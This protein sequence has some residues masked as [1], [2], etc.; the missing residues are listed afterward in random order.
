MLDTGL[1]VKECLTIEWPDVHPEP[2]GDATFG[3]LTVRS[4]S[5]KNSKPRNVPLCDR[6]LGVLGRR[7]NGQ[8]KS[9]HRNGHN[10]F[11][12]RFGKENKLRISNH[13]RVAKSADAKDLKS[14]ENLLRCPHRFPGSTLAMPTIAGDGHSA[15]RAFAVGAAILAPLRY[16]TVA[17]WMG[18]LGDFRFRHDPPP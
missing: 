15:P 3:Y 17:T 14:V 16:R 5:S 12:R 2:V 6:V 1:R 13:A 10:I 11:G 18:T 8:A 4:R 7:R 9:G